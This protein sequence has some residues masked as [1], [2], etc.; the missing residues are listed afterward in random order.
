LTGSFIPYVFTCFVFHCI[1]DSRASNEGA[2]HSH[3][4]LRRVRTRRQLLWDLTARI[5]KLLLLS[6]PLQGS[7][8]QSRRSPEQRHPQQAFG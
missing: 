3:P 8:S 7:S 1:F 5:A 2:L 6:P 4:Q